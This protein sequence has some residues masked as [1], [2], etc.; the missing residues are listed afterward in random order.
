MNCKNPKKEIVV[1]LNSV[2]VYVI[3]GIGYDDDIDKNV[4]SLNVP[5]Y[6]TFISINILIRVAPLY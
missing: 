2:V 6:H 1:S 5:N 4:L 3:I